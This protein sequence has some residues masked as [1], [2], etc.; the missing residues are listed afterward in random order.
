[1]LHMDDHLSIY[2]FSRIA[3]VPTRF[4]DLALCVDNFPSHRDVD[5]FRLIHFTQMTLTNPPNSGI[6]CGTQPTSAS[7]ASLRV[8]LRITQSGQRFC[9]RSQSFLTWLRHRDGCQPQLHALSRRWRSSLFHD[10][11]TVIL[12][13]AEKL[14]HSRIYGEI[15]AGDSEPF[16]L[17]LYLERKNHSQLLM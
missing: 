16:G 14:T 13:F 10:R 6:L 5:I 11:L 4:Q 8:F 15:W 9:G 2:T 7:S 17:M 12:S 1:M 3:D